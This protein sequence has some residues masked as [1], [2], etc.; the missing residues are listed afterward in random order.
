[1][2]DLENVQQSITTPVSPE[3]D[4]GMGV[5]RDTDTATLSTLPSFPQ[6]VAE[7]RRSDVLLLEKALKGGWPLSEKTKAETIAVARVIMEKGKTPRD[8]LRA[9]EFLLSVDKHQLEIVKAFRPQEAPT[10]A[11]QVNVTTG[12]DLSRLSDAEIEARLAALETTK[13]GG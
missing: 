5:F 6:D 7:V 13:P 8:R 9:A 4:S 1:M 10:T 11:V 2:T 12:A 3:T